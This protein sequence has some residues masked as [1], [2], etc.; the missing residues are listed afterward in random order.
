MINWQVDQLCAEAK[1]ADSSPDA[2]CQADILAVS[3]AD[4]FV[5]F[6]LFDIFSPK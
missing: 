1:A 3:A 6:M 5:F 4:V 2:Q